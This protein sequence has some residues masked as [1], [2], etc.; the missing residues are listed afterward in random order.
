MNNGRYGPILLFAQLMHG[1][2]E[3]VHWDVARVA[4]RQKEGDAVVQRYCSIVTQIGEV[5]E[6]EVK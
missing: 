5:E 2:A 3:V 4:M 1:V 6:V